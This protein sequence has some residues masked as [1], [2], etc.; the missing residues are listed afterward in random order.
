LKSGVVG[1]PVVLLLV[2]I[3]LAILGFLF[4]HMKLKIVISRSAFN[5][6]GIFMGIAL[7]L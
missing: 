3:V 4:F 5:Y 7:D 1:H 6:V 2:K